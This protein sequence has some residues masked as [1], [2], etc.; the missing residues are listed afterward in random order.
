MGYYT[1][2]TLTDVEGGPPEQTCPTCGHVG[3]WDWTELIAKHLKGWNPFEESTKWYDWEDD[4]KTFSLL[5]P[6]YTFI[7]EGD[8]EESDDKWRAYIKNGKS[9]SDHMVMEFPDFDRSQLE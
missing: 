8:G 7:I 6:D 3:E 5:Y 9:H 1:Y 4:M 2:F